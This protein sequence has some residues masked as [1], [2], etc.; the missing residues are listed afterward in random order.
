MS[1]LKEMLAQRMPQFREIRARIAKQYK[2]IQVSEVSVGQIYGGLR[3][4]KGL[5]CNTSSV[6]PDEGLKI[7]DIPIKDLTDKLPEEI[8]FLL[9]TGSMPDEEDIKDLQQDLGQRSEVPDYVW[10]VLKAMP[11]DSH[12]MAMFN[13]A[14]LVM[15][16]ESLFAKKYEEGMPK[17]DLWEPA[18]EDALNILAK[19]PAIAGFVYRLRF[20]KGPR[21]ETDPALDWG[22][23][24][25][26]ALGELDP[27]SK[28]TDLMRLYLTLHSDHEGGNVSAY[29][30]R[31]VGSALS[32]AYYAL[33]AGLNGL[34]GPL[35][36]LANQECL[37]WV[38][39]LREQFG[40]VPTDEQLRDFA[41]ETLNS[42]Q[43]IPGYGHA[44]LRVTDPRYEALLAFGR[45]HCMD[46]EIF[47]IV[48]KIFDIV[49]DVLKQVHKI[50]DPWPNVDAGSGA[51][52]YHY[53]LK[54]YPFYTVLFSVSRAMGILSQYVLARGIGRPI[55]R[56]KSIT[57]K[58]LIDIIEQK[59]GDKIDRGIY[60]E[61]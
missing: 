26:R 31:V 18:L 23:N 57:I 58:Q 56:P 35:H 52:L 59:T 25:A 51:L 32:D 7:R 48:S 21:I 13:T 55:T 43:V 47:Q 10:D 24:V 50:K 16:R 15:Q 54:E 29:T 42:G 11:A 53:G 41:W 38:E 34:A 60:A 6:Q 46:D 27:N 8:L 19:L 49:P 9:L 3:G 5:V 1:R 61:I 17:L 28:F 40:G 44:V 22:A 30:S 4:V 2:D 20:D 12:P 45:K 36:G 37:R 33:S 39:M 14:I